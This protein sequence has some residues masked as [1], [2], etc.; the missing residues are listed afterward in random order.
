MATERHPGAPRDTPQ[1]VVRRVVERLGGT[2]AQ[3]GV[4]MQP[5]RVFAALLATDS[6]RLT[7]AELVELLHVS[8]AAV[9]GAV[10]YL[11]GLR[12][13]RRERERG[14]RRD[15]YVVEDDAWHDA[16][17]A[18]TRI[19]APIITALALAREDVGPDSRAGRRLGLSVEFL[20]FVT[21]EMNGIAARWEQRQAAGPAAEAPG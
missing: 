11:A 9:S 16:T 13:I 14:S 3:S 20:E 8:P 4:P 18:T 21:E 5:A 15:V 6:G 10:R 12:W 17:V 1:E 2:L 7:S 19:H